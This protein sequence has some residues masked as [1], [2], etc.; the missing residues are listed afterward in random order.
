LKE[1]AQAAPQEIPFGLLVT[2]PVPV[3]SLLTLSVN[4]WVAKLA[5][6]AFGPST[7]TTQFPIPEQT[8][9]HPA[10]IEKVAG[11]AVRV[12][13]VPPLKNVLQV[14]PQEIPAGW[15]VTR[16]VPE[17]SLLI[18]S[19]NVWTVNV[20][21]TVLALSTVTLQVPVPEHAPLH[22]AKTEKAAGVAVRVTLEP[23]A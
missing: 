16:P 20:A 15:L 3:P 17:P 5:V 14:A 7:V 4:V 19:A 23:S 11:M 2:V 9:L 22:P 6:T 18:P 21:V 8:P 10:K 12:A 1:A 13:T